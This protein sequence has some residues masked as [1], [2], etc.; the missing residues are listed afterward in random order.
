MEAH[1]DAPILSDLL[2]VSEAPHLTVSMPTG[3]LG[4]ESAQSRVRFERLLAEARERLAE[5]GVDTRSASEL[6]SPLLGLVDDPRFWSDQD[7]G[8]LILLRPGFLR[9]VKLPAAPD[10]LVVLGERFMVRP[11]VPL[12]GSV[13]RFYVVALSINQVRVVEC[14][15]NGARAI[16]VP[17]LPKD[18]AAALGSLQFYSEVTTHAGGPRSMGHAGSIVHG[19]GDSDQERFD[20]DLLAYF[21]RV[22]E[23]LDTALPPGAPWVLAAVEHYFP[24]FSEATRGDDRLVAE[25]IPGNPELI[26]ERELG[27]RARPLLGE[28]EQEPRLRA[29]RRLERES[30]S[31]RAAFE[32]SSIVAAADSGRVWS[33][34]VSPDAPR[35]WGT[36][37]PD[38]GRLE[39]HQDRQP[40]D[41]DVIDFA[42]FHTLRN[43]GE[44]FEAQGPELAGGD[45]VAALLRY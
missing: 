26:N 38:T 15:Q 30:G 4:K 3:G 1:R 45:Q 11:L 8:L 24:L 44:V 41:V 27:E 42:V 40:G 14:G 13:R 25:G 17:N 20:T 29:L 12:L 2:E 10:E 39:I 5:V 31:A 34:F 33:L 19:H 23:V 37:E 36:Y 22:V 32:L 7:A 35:H 43:G 21:R 16:E 18:M 9:T 6:M 28:R